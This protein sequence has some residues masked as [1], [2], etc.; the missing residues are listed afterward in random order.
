[1]NSSWEGCL[2]E[3]DR[4]GNY[5]AQKS[6][7]IPPCEQCKLSMGGT[8]NPIATCLCLLGWEGETAMEAGENT[9]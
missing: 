9:L 1:M 6:S 2:T 5:S 4:D 7:K 8:L 3:Q